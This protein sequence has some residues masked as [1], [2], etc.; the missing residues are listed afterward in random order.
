MFDMKE[1]LDIDQGKRYFGEVEV[2]LRVVYIPVCVLPLPFCRRHM[3]ASLLLCL[4]CFVGT[5]L[6]SSFYLYTF[7]VCASQGT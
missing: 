4:Q 1:D 7:N 2:S 3:L 6:G 5:I